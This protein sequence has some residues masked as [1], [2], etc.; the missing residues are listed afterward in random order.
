MTGECTLLVVA[1][2][3]ISML[4]KRLLS[5]LKLP[6]ELGLVALADEKVANMPPAVLLPSVWGIFLR[7]YHWLVGVA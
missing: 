5:L 1:L 7:T 2:V 3:V 6:R 4:R